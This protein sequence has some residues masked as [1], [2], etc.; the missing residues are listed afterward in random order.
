[1]GLETSHVS[2]LQLHTCDETIRVIGFAL[3]AAGAKHKN[4]LSNYRLL[5]SCELKES[6]QLPPVGPKPQQNK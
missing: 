2:A 4:H 6:S 3:A 1:M 5:L